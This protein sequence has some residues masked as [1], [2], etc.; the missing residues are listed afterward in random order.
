MDV[1]CKIV[2]V[3]ILVDLWNFVNNFYCL[4]KL[5]VFL[6]CVNLIY[7]IRWKFSICFCVRLDVELNSC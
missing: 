7:D 1:C 4:G 5:L 3:L 2:D 6:G